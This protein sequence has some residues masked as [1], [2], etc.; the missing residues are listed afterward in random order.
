MRAKKEAVKKV[1]ES[2]KQGRKTWSPG[3]QMPEL[4]APEGF[5]TRWCRMD[6]AHIHKRLLEHWEFCT[7][8]KFTGPQFE[9]VD[10]R[11]HQ[12]KQYGGVVINNMIGMMLPPEWVEARREY[13]EDEVRSQTSSYL[14]SEGHKNRHGKIARNADVTVDGLHID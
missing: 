11:S 4:K 14:S 6:E 10:L 9:G 7:E 1:E 8:L 13:N 3:T 12:N 5:A 2:G